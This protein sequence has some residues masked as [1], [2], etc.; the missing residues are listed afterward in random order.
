MNEK[1]KAKVKELLIELIE[2][3]DW[4]GARNMLDAIGNLAE[5]STTQVP[6]MMEQVPN[7]APPQPTSFDAERQA[8][9]NRKLDSLQAE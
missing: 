1:V 5:P 4:Q 7:P 2:Q 9:L 6:P 8:K 3:E